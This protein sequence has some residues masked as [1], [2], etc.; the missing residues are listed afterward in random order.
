MT[1]PTWQLFH[2]A[3]S[4][5]FCDDVIS[6]SNNYESEKGYVGHGQKGIIDKNARLSDVKFLDPGKEQHIIQPIWNLVQL[7]NTQSFGV[8]LYG[9][10]VLQF[11]SY[12]KGHFYRPHID[13]SWKKDHDAPKADRKLSVSILL[14]DP[15]EF[16]GGDLIIE[17]DKIEMKERGAMVGFPAYMYHEVTKVTRGTRLSLVSW[18]DGP[19]WR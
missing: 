18:I 13:V 9:C 8:D 7:A 19:E 3:L 2:K 1:R 6:L 16:A 12:K 5:E 17:G 15:S 10:F 11:T 4:D 14:N